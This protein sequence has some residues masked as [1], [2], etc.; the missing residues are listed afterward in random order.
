[1]VN[2]DCIQQLGRV[3]IVR[4]GHRPLDGESGSSGVR[5]SEIITRAKSGKARTVLVDV[6]ASPYADSGGLRWL[7]HLKQVAEDN[8]LTFCTAAEPHSKVWRNLT[9]LNAGFSLYDDLHVAWQ[10]AAHPM[11]HASSLSALA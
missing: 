9:L 1:M 4:C 2:D 10:H 8:D 5:V 3:L 6:T 11:R 7:L